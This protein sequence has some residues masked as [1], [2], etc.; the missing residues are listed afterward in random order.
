MKLRGGIIIEIIIFLS[1]I[2]LLKK[3]ISHMRRNPE[4]NVFWIDF[5]IFGSVNIFRKVL[6]SSLFAQKLSF[7]H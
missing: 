3:G 5:I 7:L 6:N 2:F 1:I 4:K